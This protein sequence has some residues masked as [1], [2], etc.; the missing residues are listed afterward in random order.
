MNG[1]ELIGK[2]MGGKQIRFD[3]GGVLKILLAEYG[4][5]V[6]MELTA[7]SPEEAS[8]L[9]AKL[10][11]PV[12]VKGL[13]ARLTHKTERG[14]VR[15]NLPDAEA[16]RLAAEEIGEAAGDDLEGW[17]YSAPGDRASG[18]CGRSFSGQAVRSGGHVRSGRH[19]HRGP[20]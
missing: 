19:I 15:L 17:A 20:E 5:P 2:A 7:S 8:A 1:S 16:V 11:F 4:V 12:V 18:V 6:V 13:G 10:G 3:R 9:A 14:L